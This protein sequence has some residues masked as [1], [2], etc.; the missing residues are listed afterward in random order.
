MLADEVKRLRAER[1]K[2][3]EVITRLKAR[4]AAAAPNSSSSSSTSDPIENNQNNTSS[5]SSSTDV[6]ETIA[7][8]K[9]Q[10]TQLKNKIKK[11]A[12]SYTQAKEAKETAEQTAAE[13]KNER[14]TIPI[15]PSEPV[16][17]GASAEVVHELEIK[18]NKA[19]AIS[20]ALKKKAGETVE[21]LKEREDK[22]KTEVLN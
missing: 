3:Q 15:P 4:T 10:I 7:L 9:T 22:L 20:V 19:V 5:S 12:T 16:V 18:L 13:I 8:Q 1:K 6:N 14:D 11:L 21:K 17:P 2:Y